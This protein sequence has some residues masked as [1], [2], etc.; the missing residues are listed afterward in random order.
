MPLTSRA[1][2]ARLIVC[3]VGCAQLRHLAHVGVVRARHHAQGRPAALDVVERHHGVVVHL[4]PRVVWR[5]RSLVRQV[6]IVQVPA[7]RALLL[8]VRVGAHEELQREG[9]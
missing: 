6:R 8:R 1:I 7:L 9:C 3:E 2:S 4:A 5:R